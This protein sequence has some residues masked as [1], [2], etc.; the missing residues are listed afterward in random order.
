VKFL[1]LFLAIVGVYAQALND[2]LVFD[3]VSGV[4]EYIQRAPNLDNIFP[5]LFHASR[6]F[7]MFT[8]KALDFGNPVQTAFNILLHF[9]NA[10]LLYVLLKGFYS[11]RTAYL[12]ALFFAVNPAAI[13][14]VCYLVQRSQLFMMFF[15]LSM[16]VT[17]WKALSSKWSILYFLASLA[18]YKLAISSKE[19]GITLLAVYPLLSLVKRDSWKCWIYPALMSV[20]GLA[21]V[22]Y[23]SNYGIIK[24]GEETYRDTL[25]KTCGI[26]GDLMLRSILTQSGLF[27]GYFLNW[28]VPSNTSI[29]MRVEFV[30]ESN[31][32]GLIFFTA[33]VFGSLVL[34]LRKSTRYLGLGLVLSAALFLPEFARVRLGEIFVMYRSY[35]YSLGYM[36]AI[37]W[38]VDRL[39]SYDLFYGVILAVFAGAAFFEAKNFD[40][41]TQVWKVAAEQIDMER[42]EIACQGA[43]AFSN[44]GGQL[45]K[46]GKYQEAIE[47]L[48]TANR[49]NPYWDSP[50][51]N[52]GVAYLFSGKMAQAEM[53]FSSLVDSED[54]FIQ[55]QS[56][57]FLNKIRGQSEF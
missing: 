28:L 50:L 7:T 26:Y 33:Y 43:R 23:V 15:G 13:Y 9:A 54:T 56:R 24:V 17:Y 20:V 21:L 2:P 16:A 8:F 4:P 18:C 27:F 40:S 5:D 11:G 42:P 29:D 34:L 35:I 37:G 52:L 38:V 1:I 44:A 25:V 39:K 22:Q 46:E 57:F 19:S 14:A 51:S 6:R 3:S 10:L 32:T 31:I 12:V 48:K 53:V 47:Y 36:I 49:L 30:S 55:D 41:E 45:V